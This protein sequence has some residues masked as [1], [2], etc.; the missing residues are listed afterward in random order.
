MKI[1]FILPACIFLFVF[2]VL[3]WGELPEYSVMRTTEKIVIDGILDEKDW[4]AAQPSGN[5]ACPWWTQGEQ[6]QTEVKMLWNDTFLY[7]AFK[8]SDTRIWADHY[9]TNSTTYKD[10]CVEI[11]WNPNPEGTEKYNMF[12]M[13]C[14]G[15]LLSVY[16]G[17]GKSISELISRIMVPHIAQSIRGTVN[18]D[19]DIDTGWILEI[20][21]RFSD[22]PELSKRPSPVDGDMWRVGL[23]RCG[24]K[25][26][27]Q[28]S[29]WSP[30]VGE[31]PSFHRPKYFGKVF[32]S[33]KSVR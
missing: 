27:E 13:N 22:Y 16:T 25:T 21:I 18:N 8:C 9:D 31:K 10:D 5:F 29:Q 4:A 32:F 1:L 17:S 14:I 24:G 12:E 6:E 23:N 15:N 2:P 19:S 33:N 30:E 20:A 3:S 26:N 11:F 7:V 28:Y